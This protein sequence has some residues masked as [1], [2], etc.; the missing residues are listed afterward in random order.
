LNACIFL[1]TQK[2]SFISR[3]ALPVEN[4]IKPADLFDGEIKAK[5]VNKRFFSMLDFSNRYFFADTE[6]EISQ[7]FIK[8]NR[9]NINVDILRDINS[10][11]KN[12]IR[13]VEFAYLTENYDKKETKPQLVAQ[14]KIEKFANFV[15]SIEKSTIR[16]TLNSICYVIG[17]KDKQLED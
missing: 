7:N 1:Q 2:G 8:E 12:G 13:N 4:I 6:Q 11:Y 9:E 14:K 10:L 3:I 5:E 17:V 15:N 16:N